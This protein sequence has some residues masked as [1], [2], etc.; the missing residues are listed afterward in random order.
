[1]G[2]GPSSKSSTVLQVIT[3]GNAHIDDSELSTKVVI[4]YTEAGKRLVKNRQKF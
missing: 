4:H 3:V 2:Y 1:M